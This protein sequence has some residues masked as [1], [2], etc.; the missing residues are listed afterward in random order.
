MGSGGRMHDGALK[1][2]WNRHQSLVV[3][4]A[5]SRATRAIGGVIVGV[6]SNGGDLGPGVAAPVAGP[7]RRKRQPGRPT[8]I[9][10]GRKARRLKVC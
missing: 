5:K 1:K 3:F 9:E 6:Q 2:I 8:E 4:T 10:G 7:T